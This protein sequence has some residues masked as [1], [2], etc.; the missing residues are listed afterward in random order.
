MFIGHV[1]RVML[2]IQELRFPK[3]KLFSNPKGC[4]KTTFPIISLGKQKRQRGRTQGQLAREARQIKTVSKR[5]E[6]SCKH[7]GTHTPVFRL[8]NE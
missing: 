6:G 5:A 8:Q 2:S 7:W 3:R 4:S 1:R